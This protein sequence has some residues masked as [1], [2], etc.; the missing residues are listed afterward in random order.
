MK[1][2]IILIMSALLIL[3]VLILVILSVIHSIVM[4]SYRYDDY[5][6]EHYLLYSDIEEEYTRRTFTVKSGENNLSAYLYGSQNDKGIIV[7]APGHTDSNDIKLYEIRYFVDAGYKVVCFDYTGY[8][9]SEGKT[10][11]GYTQAV[12]DLDAVLNYLESDTELQ[13]Q[14]LFLF[15]HSL[16][17]YAAAAVLNKSHNISAVVSASG[18]DTPAE[19]WQCSVKRFTGV[20]YPVIKPLNSLFIHMK[21]GKDKDLSAVEGINS[22]DI[23]VL[24]ISAENDIFYGGEKSPV[25]DK[26]DIITNKNCSFILMDRENHNGHYDY[27]LTDDALNYQSTKIMGDIDKEAYMEHNDEVMGRIVE[28]FDNSSIH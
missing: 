8:Y 2:M 13:K 1:K 23:P 18:F 28:F 12:Y 15:G 5:D 11:G 4:R 16:G 10:F 22:M 6:S 14:N 26:K 20:L 21:Y 19:Q 7:V 25:Y 17:G 24:V 3:C 9:T 27:F